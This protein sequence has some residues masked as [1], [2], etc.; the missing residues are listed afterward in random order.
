METRLS[1]ILKTTNATK[2]IKITLENTY[3]FVSGTYNLVAATAASLFVKGHLVLS[4]FW[5]LD[6]CNFCYILKKAAK[7]YFLE[8]S[9]R[10]LKTRQKWHPYATHYGETLL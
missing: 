2:F 5:H 9:H 1:N 3:K 4:N 8:A 10:C 6:C 7:L